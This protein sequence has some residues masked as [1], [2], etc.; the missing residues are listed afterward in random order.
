[1]RTRRRACAATCSSCVTITIVSPSSPSSS[2]SASTASVLTESRLPVGSSHSSSARV[3][4][5]RAGDRDALLLAAGEA[6]GQE[7]RAVRHARPARARRAR[8]RARPSRAARGRPRR[9][10]RSRARVR[11][12]SRLNVWKTKPIRSRPQRGALVVAQAADVDA[13]EQVGARGRAVQAAEDVQQ[14]R[15]AGA[16]RPDDRQRR[17]ALEREV[18]VAQ[19]DDR[20]IGCRTSGPTPLARSPGRRGVGLRRAPRARAT[21]ARTPSAMRRAFAGHG[22]GRPLVGC[23]R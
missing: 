13:V 6:R 21:S 12:A 5:Q 15:L 11:C 10:S 20:R 1:M 17:P 2:N 19:R 14:R 9:A 8:A 16:R 18:H 7:V 23:R 3:A 22:P 4:Q